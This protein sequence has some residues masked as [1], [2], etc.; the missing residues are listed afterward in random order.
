MVEEKRQVVAAMPWW[1]IIAP[2]RKSYNHYKDILLKKSVGNH[3]DWYDFNSII[4]K[5]KETNFLNSTWKI[6]RQTDERVLA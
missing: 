1:E 5:C 3:Q 4:Q 2:L 6:A